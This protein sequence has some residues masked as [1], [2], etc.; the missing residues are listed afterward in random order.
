MYPQIENPRNENEKFW[1]N[2][3]SQNA[4]DWIKKMKEGSC[5]YS[6][7]LFTVSFSNR[8]LISYMDGRSVWDND[9]PIPGFHSMQFFNWLLED[10]RELKASDLFDNKT[11]WRNK[12]AALVAQKA[13]EQKA[14]DGSSYVMPGEDFNTGL[15][16]IDKLTSSDQ[17]WMIS[18]GGL[19][20]R[21]EAG[22]DSHYVLFTIDWKTLTPYLSKKGHFLIYD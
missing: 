19:V 17:W 15:I 13:K 16:N 20:F 7:R 9:K 12:L 5:E 3:V 2:L 21:L 6:H 4:N 8:H 14:E 1:N 11:D 22:D 10:K 18:K